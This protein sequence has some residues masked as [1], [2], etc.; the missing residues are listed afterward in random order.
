MQVNSE[1]LENKVTTDHSCMDKSYLLLCNYNHILFTDLPWP[2]NSE[3]IMIIVE[4]VV[5]FYTNNFNNNFIRSPPSFLL[6]IYEQIQ[7]IVSHSNSY[8]INW[9]LYFF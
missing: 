6:K 4:Q 2:G 5:H 7:N 1:V 8:K 3:G 9:K